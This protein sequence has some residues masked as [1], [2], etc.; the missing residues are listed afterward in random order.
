MVNLVAVP[1]GIRSIE[2][3]CPRT[4]GKRVQ[5]CSSAP[6]R[7]LALSSC[8]LCSRSLSW[9]I[10]WTQAVVVWGHLWAFGSQLRVME[11]SHHTVR[12]GTQVPML[13]FMRQSC[14]P[15][16][17]LSESFVASKPILRHFFGIS[18]LG[19]LHSTSVSSLN[20]E[21]PTLALIFLMV[22]RKA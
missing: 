3:L 13:V 20:S 15:W 12:E 14:S 21:S 9:E 19:A 10:R 5:S 18:V 4:L 2:A 11:L 17:L 7:G 16:H 6:D 22:L 8:P 1:I